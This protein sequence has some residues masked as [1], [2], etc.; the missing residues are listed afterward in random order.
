MDGSDEANK[1]LREL[2]AMSPPPNLRGGPGLHPQ[3]TPGAGVG[4]DISA[5]TTTSLRIDGIPGEVKVRLRAPGENIPHRPAVPGGAGGRALPPL[6]SAA[7]PDSDYHGASSTAAHNGS[8]PSSSRSS[9]HSSN[10]LPPIIQGS[11]QAAALGAAAAAGAAA[12]GAIPPRSRPEELLRDIITL[13]DE[14]ARL[15]MGRRLDA[16]ET[17]EEEEEDVEEE[18]EGGEGYDEDDFM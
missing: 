14:A 15:A 5:Q 18:E 2:I 6:G 3:M 10:T 7:G 1:Y 13:A 17:E 8:S 12:G 16:D 4:A 11:A 9:N